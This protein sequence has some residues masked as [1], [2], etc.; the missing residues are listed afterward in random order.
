MIW[1]WLFL[2]GMQSPFWSHVLGKPLLLREAPATKRTKAMRSC[3]MQF[4]ATISRSSSQTNLYDILPPT[5]SDAEH[6]ERGKLTLELH[7]YL[8]Q[9]VDHGDAVAFE[10]ISDIGVG[11]GLRE[12]ELSNATRFPEQR[13]RTRRAK[14]MSASWRGYSASVTSDMSSQRADPMTARAVGPLPRGCD[15]R[16][17]SSTLQKSTKK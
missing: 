12:S 10:T 3:G 5:S 9:L 2:R 15:T 8:R 4:K 7:P 14:S 6:H 17:G 13:R 1:E 11:H 16:T